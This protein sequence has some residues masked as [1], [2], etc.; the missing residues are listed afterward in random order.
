MNIKLLHDFISMDYDELEEDY[1]DN[2]L[3]ELLDSIPTLTFSPNHVTLEHSEGFGDET[4]N[5]AEYAN[6][7]SQMLDDKGFSLS[8]NKKYIET[9][10]ESK[11][12]EIYINLVKDILIGNPTN[13]IPPRVKLKNKRIQL[14]DLREPLNTKEITLSNFADEEKYGISEQI[15]MLIKNLPRYAKGLESILDAIEQYRPTRYSRHAKPLTSI[16]RI[17]PS[18]KE[19]REDLYVYY[20]ELYPKYNEMKQIIKT[21][22]DDWDEVEELIDG[23][24]ERKPSPE[25]V[26]EL[27]KELEEL[28][29]IYNKMSDKNNY[30]IR[31]GRLKYQTD[32][33]SATVA[34]K[35]A[36]NL[37]IQEISKV[38]GSNQTKKL[39]STYDKE[40]DYSSEKSRKEV[41]EQ[42]GKETAIDPNEQKEEPT[43]DMESITLIDKVDPLFL[44][45][46][47]GGIIKNRYS[48]TSW[49]Y[50]RDEI[51]ALIE[52]LSEN[53]SM[54]SV[55]EKV[56]DSHN[57]YKDQAFDELDERNYFYFP[58]NSDAGSEL[59]TA[60]VDINVDEIIELHTSLI[61]IISR[62][63]EEP[64]VPSQLPSMT[65]PDDFAP[66]AS[67]EKNQRII[68]RG[69]QKRIKRDEMYQ[70]FN[71]FQGREVGR[72]G[73]KR[74][75]ASFGKF[76]NSLVE[77]FDIADEYYGNPVRDLMIP[78]I[79]TPSFLNKNFLGPIINHGPDNLGKTTFGLYRDWSVAILTPSQIKKITSYLE[80]T[81]LTTRK[82]DI[83]EKR[84]NKVLLVL[85]DMSPSNIENDLSWFA[86]QFRGLA[87]RDSS[88]DISDVEL[89]GRPIKNIPYDKKK[90]RTL[91]YQLLWQLY[92]FRN[93][94]KGNRYSK[95]AINEFA[96]AYEN[97]RNLKL[98]SHQEIILSA[99]DEIRKML[100]KPIYY[101]N[102]ELNR[103]NDMY[104]TIDLMKSKYNIDLTSNDI[105]KIVDEIDS[106]DSLA[107]RLGTNSEVIYHVKSLYR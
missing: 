37:V 29:N 24:M 12:D 13:N 78:Y 54:K 70:M 73:D 84:A 96:K 88:F 34:D 107:K 60:G 87:K 43:V 25:Y 64:T 66:G 101:N 56:L 67:E 104:D 3:D 61:I 90:N 6:E 5:P 49:E 72:I 69:P 15:K 14:K 94:F 47:E 52:G 38:L 85:Q 79:T 71:L 7:I 74:E 65:E 11:P 98:A 41:V 50:I 77:L 100:G 59:L 40:F 31:T 32:N 82:S 21:V 19:E 22:L 20:E 75:K 91:Y 95:E 10:K 63:L 68:P 62:L 36:K 33:V 83:M 9:A 76:A 16:S 51:E 86:N 102:C 53:S 80:Y 44:I 103:F 45:A 28:R 99:H 35:E 30:I 8:Y 57:D 93:E 39:V 55:Y 17:D 46:A 92:E 42:Y 27:D 2:E 106:F 26:E 81:Q 58:L 89:L 105:I 1:S 48:I 23:K 18:N 4:I 97:Q